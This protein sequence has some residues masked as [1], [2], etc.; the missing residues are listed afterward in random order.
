MF[1]LPAMLQK[2]IHVGEFEEESIECLNSLTKRVSKKL[3][4]Q[5]DRNSRQ[6]FSRNMYISIN[7]VL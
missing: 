4:M 3:E 1:N 6:H 2:Y 7:I 5:F